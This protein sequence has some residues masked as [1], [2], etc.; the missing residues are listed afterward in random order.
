MLYTERLNESMIRRPYSN[1]SECLSKKGLSFQDPFNK[2]C[3]V[4]WSVKKLAKV[5]AT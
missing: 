5:N 3:F 1:N 2:T 4:M